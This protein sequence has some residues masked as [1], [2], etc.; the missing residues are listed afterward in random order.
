MRQYHSPHLIE[1]IVRRSKKVAV[2]APQPGS[3]LIETRAISVG[4]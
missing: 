2:T 3:K 1:E 4:L